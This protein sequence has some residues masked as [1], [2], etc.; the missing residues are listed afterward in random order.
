MASL[1]A[2]IGRSLRK[3]YHALPLS[4]AMRLKLKQL[5][6]RGFA[7][8]L[9]G[10]HAYRRWDQQ[11]SD[12]SVAEL[13][14]IAA[15]DDPAPLSVAAPAVPLRAKLALISH[16]A[17]PHG[18]QYLA[19]NLVRE[20]QRMHQDVEVLMQNGGL[21][22][23]EFEAIA[24]LHRLYQMDQAELRAFAVRLREQGV[25]AVIANTTVPGL[26]IA[27]FREAGLRVVSL[28]HELPGIIAKYGLGQALLDLVDASDRVVISSEAV[29][30]GVDG[31]VPPEALAGK[32]ILR[33]QGLFTRSRY[34]GLDDL[35]E[36]RANL[37]RKLGVSEQAVVVLAVGFGDLR[38]GLDLLARAAA[39]AYRSEPNLHVVWVGNHE[40]EVKQ[41]VDR[42]LEEAGIASR[43]HFVGLDFDTDDYYAGA[44]VYALPS[45]E[46]PFPSVVLES[47]SVGTPVVAFEGTGGGADLVADRAGLTVRAFDVD[48]YAQALLRICRD[49]EL[50][51]RYA[52]AGR[53]MV[54][55]EYSF[56]RYAQDLLELCEVPAPRVSAIVPNYNYAHYLPH[57]LA[58]L[59]AQTLPLTEILVLDDASSDDSVAVVQ[60][61]RGSYHPEP[62]IV[63]NERNSGSVFRQWL[64]GARRATGEFVW[65]AEADDEARPEMVES[66]VG[67]L[68]ADTSLVMAYCQS[69]AI[70]ADGVV[71]AADYTGYTDDLS[72]DRWRSAYTATGAEEAIAGLAIKNTVPNVSAAVFRREALLRVLSEHEDEIVSYRV[73]GDWIVYLR[74][75]ALGRI[76][77]EPRALNRH[78]RHTSSVTAALDLQRHYDEVVAAQ[79]LAAR[80]Y[81][82]KEETSV[83]ASNYAAHLREHFGLA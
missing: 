61:R 51:A 16:D 31:L 15:T 18:A 66:L 56:R 80:L 78:R 11:V 30:K 62:M 25:Q 13:A 4:W 34:R 5:I 53:D 7:P 37:R 47:L 83:A 27:P 14:A 22:E 24:P 42:M 17:N 68:R 43:F 19:L 70:D 6:F 1:K 50:R 81:P 3:V 26:V 46:D 39:I 36:P 12:G 48:A 69:E 33:P 23:P 54:D 72:R 55:T 58:T 45:R 38:K 35:S 49:G 67:A 9:S 60:A 79:A 8:V 10:T 20:L 59:S 40:D 74:L 63:R 29:R 28:I 52:R 73:A 65:I 44:D 2:L 41:D 21:L 77:F 71:I 75:L 82:L 32:L 64:A 76:H 57:R